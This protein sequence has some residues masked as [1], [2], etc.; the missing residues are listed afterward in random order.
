LIELLVV[1]AIIAILASMLLPALNQAKEKARGAVCQSNLKS[2]GTIFA[3]YVDSY[4]YYPP[5][6]TNSS[7]FYSGS[8]RWYQI[9]D[10]EYGITYKSGSDNTLSCPSEN[11]VSLSASLPSHYGIN[12]LLAGKKMPE[13][14]DASRALL[15]GEVRRSG[16]DVITWGYIKASTFRHGQEDPRVTNAMIDDRATYSPAGGRQNLAFVD[17]HVES[18]TYRVMTG[19]ADDSGGLETNPSR[20]GSVFKRGIVPPY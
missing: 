12:W 16:Y 2:L 4:E 18:M 1:I 6:Q 15:L 7:G 14:S 20:T 5:R 13:I 9:F 11:V 3:M 8:V 10:T 17:T 19:I